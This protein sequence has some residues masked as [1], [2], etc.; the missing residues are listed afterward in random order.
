MSECQHC[1]NCPPSGVLACCSA[2][3]RMVRV[4]DAAGKRTVTPFRR[5]AGVEPASIGTETRTLAG[6]RSLCADYCRRPASMNVTTVAQSDVHAQAVAAADEFGAR[7]LETERLGRL[8]DQTVARLIEMDVPR[9]VMPR[10]WEGLELGFPLVVD[11]VMTLA[12][13]CMSTA[14]CAALYAEHPWILAHLDEQAQADV[15]TSGPNVPV[16]MSVAAFGQGRRVDGGLELTGT[17]PFVSGCDHA[18]WFMVSTQWTSETSDAPAPWSGGLCLVPRGDVTIDHESW[19][20]AGLRGTGSKTLH[21]DRVFVPEHRIR[22]SVA[23][24]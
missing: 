19:H 16:C 15:W 17:W 12:H 14:W 5:R 13:G 23:L 2:S 21:V 6:V 4:H 22:D 24:V 3:V 11:F 9:M 8:P 10:Q 18:P 20:V 1:H 7:V